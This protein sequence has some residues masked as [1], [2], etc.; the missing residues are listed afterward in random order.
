MWDCIKNEEQDLQWLVSGLEKGTIVC[1][2][3]RS[4]D[5]KVAPNI[6][7]AGL[8]L[9]CTKAKRMLRGNF[10]EKSTTASSYRGELLGLVAIHTILLALCQFYNIC[11]DLGGIFCL[12]PFFCTAKVIIDA[13]FASCCKCLPIGNKGY[14]QKHV[15]AES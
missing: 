10:Y 3:D 8:V 4:Y 9:C 15:S 14:V 13:L 12:L 5:R 7:G 1:V 11:F 2:K 6:S